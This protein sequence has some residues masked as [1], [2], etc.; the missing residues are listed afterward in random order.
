MAKGEFGGDEQFIDAFAGCIDRIVA[1]LFNEQP[2]YIIDNESESCRVSWIIHKDAFEQDNYYLVLKKIELKDKV[3]CF[4]YVSIG[5]E[6]LKIRCC[7]ID[8]IDRIQELISDNY[9]IKSG[10]PN[11]FRQYTAKTSL[12]NSH[13]ISSPS[14]REEVVVP[15]ENSNNYEIKRGLWNLTFLHGCPMSQEEYSTVESIIEMYIRGDG[16]LGKKNK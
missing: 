10:L 15:S 4:V 11:G 1:C 13:I 14:V 5:G 9:W 7:T 8:T 2:S 3:I 6:L 16:P 12:G